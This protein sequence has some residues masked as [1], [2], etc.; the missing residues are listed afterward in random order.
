M[1]RMDANGPD[2]RGL[3]SYLIGDRAGQEGGVL[4]ARMLA[5]PAGVPEVAVAW[6]HALPVG[7][8]TGYVL[9][10]PR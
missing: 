8:E 5:G 10:C 7:Q 1:V 2:I 4:V 9:P 6:G 3:R